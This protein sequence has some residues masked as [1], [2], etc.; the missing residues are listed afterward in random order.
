MN[1]RLGGYYIWLN[2]LLN[3]GNFYKSPKPKT[4]KT[5]QAAPPSKAEA[6]KFLNLHEVGQKE[7]GYKV[8]SKI[9]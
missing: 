4:E 8:L 5:K 7:R 1:M 3:Q 2:L 9:K 6:C